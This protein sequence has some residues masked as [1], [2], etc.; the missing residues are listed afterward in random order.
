M[1]FFNRFDKTKILRTKQMEER[2]LKDGLRHT[3]FNTAKDKYIGDWKRNHKTGKGVLLTGDKDLYEGDFVDNYRHGFG[4]SAFY[5]PK[6][7]VFALKYRGDWKNGKK[8]GRGL[9]VYP[10][11]G[12]YIGHFKNGKRYG[13]GQ[14]WYICG[15]FYDGD[16]VKD[17]REGLGLLVREDGNRYEG[18]WH[19]D[20][21]HGAGRFYF[22]NMG[23]LQTGVWKNDICTFSTMKNLPF[24]Q[25][26]KSP[27]VYPLS[28]NTLIN[29]NEIIAAEEKKA[30]AGFGEICLN[31]DTF[32]LF[33]PR[34]THYSKMSN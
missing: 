30:L 31:D 23:I 33:S 19:K 29:L 5:L 27:T 14:M 10:E 21:K 2:T 28:V 16:W 32:E 34:S 25:S 3:V 7:N 20:Q 18:S 24:R 8:E 26:S 4:V 17:Q 11:V 12:F 1:P 22:L 6:H 9:R 13:Y 15:S